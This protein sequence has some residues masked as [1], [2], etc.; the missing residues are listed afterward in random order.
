MAAINPSL[1]VKHGD[2]KL[3]G[4]DTY[5]AESAR[6]PHATA[7]SIPLPD[8]RFEQTFLR[9]ATKYVDSGA[10]LDDHEASL[11]EE[12]ALVQTAR[13]SHELDLF[14][15]IQWGALLWMSLRDQVIAQYLQGTVLSIATLTLF[16][17]A[18]SLIGGF[19]G[20]A[21]RR[22]SAVKEG[23]GVGFLRSWFR[24]F[25]GSSRLASR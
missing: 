14:R 20:G 9:S 3:F 19:F 1:A 2:D 11:T 17:W 5:P 7:P 13:S 12:A 8:L 23:E 4:S 15:D 22:V 25:T 10:E 18:R 6:H 24:G 21:S 16:P